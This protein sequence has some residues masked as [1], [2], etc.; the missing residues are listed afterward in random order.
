MRAIAFDFQWPCQ[1]F[2]RLAGLLLCAL[3]SQITRVVYAC[4]ASMSTEFGMCWEVNMPEEIPANLDPSKGGKARAL[5]LS[6]ERRREI[7]VAAAQKRWGVELPEA[8]HPGIVK[9]ANMEFPCAVLSDGT[10]VLTETNFMALM[11]IYRSGALSVR[12]SEDK[13]ARMPLYLAF[14]NLKPFIDK[15]LGDVH[16]KPLKYRTESGTVAHGIPAEI[17]PKICDVWLDAQKEGVLGKRQQLIAAKAEILM[18]GLAHVGII[19]LVDEATGYQD[20]RARDALARI[21]EAFVA[22]ELKKWVRTFQPDFYKELFRLR[23]WRYTGTCK[24]PAYVG[25]LTNDLVYARLAPGVL[26]ELRRVN[27][28]NE[29]GNRKSKHHQWLTADLGHPKLQQHLS[30]LIALMRASLSWQQFEKMVNMALPKQVKLPLFD[31]LED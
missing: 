24:R 2:K 1:L 13:G 7:A 10:R 14:K 4:S 3:H 31:G 8:K 12:R 21:L 29:K 23:G 9:I 18:R 19:A 5:N 27:P 17:I 28:V 22:K 15:H 16:T 26:E 6:P 11:G 30:A 25:H 20:E